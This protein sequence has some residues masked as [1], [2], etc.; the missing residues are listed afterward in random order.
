MWDDIAND[1][2]IAHDVEVKTPT[3][4]HERSPT[5]FGFVTLLGVQ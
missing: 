1:I 3:A 2:G 4:I 5:I